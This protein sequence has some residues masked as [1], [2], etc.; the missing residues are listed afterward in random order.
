[1]GSEKNSL[2]PISRTS[3]IISGDAE[4]IKISGQDGECCMVLTSS[5][6]FS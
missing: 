6:S 4:V 1:M 5:R 3:F 2:M